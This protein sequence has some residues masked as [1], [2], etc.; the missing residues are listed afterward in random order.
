MKILGLDSKVDVRN[1]IQPAV[2]FLLATL[3][4]QQDCIPLFTSQLV[5][6]THC[7]RRCRRTTVS[8]GVFH[9]GLLYHAGLMD[10][11]LRY[12]NVVIS[13]LTTFL[14]LGENN[15]LPI[16]PHL[17]VTVLLSWSLSRSALIARCRLLAT[18]IS[19]MPSSW[20]V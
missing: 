8:G 4:A 11:L 16:I 5:I 1:P 10:V 9:V 2:P 18:A 14:S 7:R 17:P 20:R 13:L 6:Q 12:V 3:V 19:V 15:S